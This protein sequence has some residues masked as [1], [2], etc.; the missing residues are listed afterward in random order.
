MRAPVARFRV[1]LSGRYR[2]CCESPRSEQDRAPPAINELDQLSRTCAGHEAASRK[3]DH[4]EL[5]PDDTVVLRPGPNFDC[6]MGG[7]AAGQ[8]TLSEPEQDPAREDD[9]TERG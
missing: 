7:L 1:L 9:H 3:R 8:P 2:I 6:L 4:R 5:V